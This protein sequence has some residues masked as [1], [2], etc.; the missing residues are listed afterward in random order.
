ML[1]IVLGRTCYVYLYDS[2]FVS[3]T[4]L[5]GGPVEKVSGRDRLVRVLAKVIS[6]MHKGKQERAS[7]GLAAASV[8]LTTVRD[9]QSQFFSRR[10]SP[11]SYRR[12]QG[13]YH[14]RGKGR[15]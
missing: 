10:T 9:Y 6:R 1:G 12:C 7:T 15:S 5:Q 4:S 13:M 2:S 11:K 8:V 14:A 3:D